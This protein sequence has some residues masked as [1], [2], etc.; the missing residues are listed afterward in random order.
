MT[1]QF[2]S[3]ALQENKKILQAM[4]HAIIRLESKQFF[5]AIYMRFEHFLDIIC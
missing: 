5:Y 4:W 2:F 1:V 3:R